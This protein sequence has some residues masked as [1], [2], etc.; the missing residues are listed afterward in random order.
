MMMVRLMTRATCHC[1]MRATC[2]PEGGVPTMFIIPLNNEIK[3]KK[4]F[5]TY[6][7]MLGQGLYKFSNDREGSICCYQP[8][9][10]LKMSFDSN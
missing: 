10:L 8:M 5:E 4:T 2:F 9:Y 1:E 7:S 6:V 3:K